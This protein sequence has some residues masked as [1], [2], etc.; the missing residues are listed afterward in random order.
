VEEHGKWSLLSAA[1][2]FVLPSYSENFGLVIAE[3]LSCALPVITTRA[4][5]WRELESHR[6][7]WWT[8]T[9]HEAL[10]E[11]LSVATK[12][13]DDELR[14]MGERGRALI[15]AN[16]SW[17]KLSEKMLAVLEWLIGRRDQPAWLL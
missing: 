11:A 12:R 17:D 7:G 3:A 13:S 9:G 5:P 2:L 6:C 10:A 4:T 8:E 16:Y 1:D 14:Q 15:R